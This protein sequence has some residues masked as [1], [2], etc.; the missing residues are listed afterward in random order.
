MRQADSQSGVLPPLLVPSETTKN[1]SPYEIKIEHSRPY[2]HST[3]PLD[4]WLDLSL[5][6]IVLI[7]SDYED[8]AD[9]NT[10]DTIKDYA[11]SGS[12]YLE[13]NLATGRIYAVIK[14]MDKTGARISSRVLERERKKRRPRDNP[15]IAKSERIS[16]GLD[17]PAAQDSTVFLHK[18]GPIHV[19]IHTT[20]V[21]SS[22]CR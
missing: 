8:Q 13:D 22:S 12:T 21:E 15:E 6:T 4:A 20:P 19:F 1:E 5:L 11:Y 16:Q 7:Q 3:T 17:R 14:I 9:P 18:K 2:D 10:A